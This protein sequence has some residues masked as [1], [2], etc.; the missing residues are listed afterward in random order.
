MTGANCDV[1]REENATANKSKDEPCH[2]G[3]MRK[4]NPALRAGYLYKD[5]CEV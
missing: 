3:L 4:K 2:F 5:F 1:R